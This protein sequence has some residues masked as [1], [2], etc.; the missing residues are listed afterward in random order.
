[1]RQVPSPATLPSRFGR[2]GLLLVP[3]LEIHPK[4]SPISDS[5]G[6]RRILLRDLSATPQNTF[7]DTF[8]NWRIRWER[9]INIAREYFEGDMSDEVVSKAMN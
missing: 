9:R 6:E 8:Q 3:K 4:S 5:R 7:Q 2:C 1:M